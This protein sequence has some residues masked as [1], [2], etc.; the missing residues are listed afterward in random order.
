MPLDTRDRF[1]LVYPDQ[2]RLAGDTCD[3]HS[4]TTASDGRSSPE[5]SMGFAAER[6]LRAIA[7]SDHDGV[8]SIDICTA[9][10]RDLG[11]EVIPAIEVTTFYKGIETH[12]LGHLIDHRSEALK[13]LIARQE[14]SRKAALLGMLE[15]LTRLGYPLNF[16]EVVAAMPD[17][18]SSFYGRPHIAKAMLEKGYIAEMGHAF[19]DEF[20]GNTGRAYVQVSD[21]TV[22]EAIAGI[23]AAGGV[24]VVAHPGSWAPTEDLSEE[25]LAQF[26]DWGV[27]GMEVLH[28]RHSEEQ[29]AKFWGLHLKLGLF[30]TAGAD[31]HGTYYN[32]IKMGSVRA[33]YHWL[34]AMRE[35][36]AGRS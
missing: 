16:E 15:N 25:D 7:I 19:T 9:L 1:G 31:C 20:I 13:P 28:I 29:R 18:T 23:H 10:G 6:G 3:F 32:P 22:E 2:D 33:P 21:V 14:G 11:V 34:Q 4:H 5:Q 12:I 8:A 24:A 17:P 26:R 35:Y 30:P 36:R 27:D